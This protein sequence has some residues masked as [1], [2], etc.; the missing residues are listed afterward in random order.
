MKHLFLSILLIIMTIAVSCRSSKKINS[1]AQSNNPSTLIQK[2]PEAW[3]RNLMPA[4]GKSEPEQYLIVNGARAEITD[5]DTTWIRKNC[6]RVQPIEV[7]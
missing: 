5:Y 3:Y 4:P 2:C 1:A 7:H 6:P